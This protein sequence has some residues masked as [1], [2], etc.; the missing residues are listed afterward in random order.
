MLHSLRII[1]FFTITV[2]A[3][4]VSAQNV[5]VDY[6][7]WT[8]QA[9]HV[10]R[11]LEKGNV[12][13][14]LRKQVADWR[15]VFEQAS[16]VNKTSIATVMSQIEALGPLPDDGTVDTLND[17]REALAADLYR[18]LFAEHSKGMKVISDIGNSHSSGPIQEIYSLTFR[19]ASIS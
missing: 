8:K 10:E 12:S 7:L 5:E 18:L 3:S 17:R 1:A 15:T 4:L 13:E 16:E 19:N 6:Y 14:S 11:Q 9:K 2:F